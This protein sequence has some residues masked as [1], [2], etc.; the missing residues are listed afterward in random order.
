ML[1]LDK[2]LEYKR[3]YDEMD[4]YEREKLNIAIVGSVVLLVALY[5]ILNSVETIR[6]FL[7]YSRPIEM[8]PY[9]TTLP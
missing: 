1:V 7:G 8:P 5:L 9:P 3:R 6:H 2:L 4:S